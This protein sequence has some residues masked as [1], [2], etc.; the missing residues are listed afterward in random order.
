MPENP[1][2]ITRMPFNKVFKKRLNGDLVL[3]SKLSVSGELFEPD[4]VVKP[5]ELLA[6]V[7]FHKRQGLELAIVVSG[8]TYI[9]R[10][11]FV[12]TVS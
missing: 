7:D 12:D 9:L 5:G 10:G 8:D 6:G 11:F 3:R 2:E 4:L 1:T